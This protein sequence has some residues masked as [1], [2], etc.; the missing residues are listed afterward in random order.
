MRTRPRTAIA[1]AVGRAARAALGLGLLLALSSCSYGAIDAPL[2]LDVNAI[3]S[4]AVRLD[5]TLTDSSSKATVVHPQ[6]YAGEYASVPLVLSFAAPA[7][8]AFSVTL[9]AYDANSV[10]VGHGTASGVWGG[11]PQQLQVTMG[12]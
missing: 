6:F 11:Q 10:T 9:Q 8:G 5:A 4:T 7:A 3:P 12:P 2:A 1:N